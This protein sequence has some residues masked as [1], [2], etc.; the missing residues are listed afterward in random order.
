MKV[1]TCLR[2]CDLEMLLSPSCRA[3]V[4]WRRLHLAN[5]S[6]LMLAARGDTP[7]HTTIVCGRAVEHRL[8]TDV[9]D[10]LAHSRT[11]GTFH[12]HGLVQT[13]DR[14]VATTRGRECERVGEES[15]R[16][17][18]HVQGGGVLCNACVWRQPSCGGL[19]SRHQCAVQ[20]SY[21]YVLLPQDP[22]AVA[23]PAPM[24]YVC[25]PIPVRGPKEHADTPKRKRTHHRGRDG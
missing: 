18:L 13:E 11:E 2:T 22:L 19:H 23:V 10:T 7:W 16:P 9:M 21:R 17:P 20:G 6:R 15:E 4:E 12:P 8:Q 3:T 24:S 1:L 25:L 5:N 14:D